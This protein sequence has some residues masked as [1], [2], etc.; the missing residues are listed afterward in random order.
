M[1][2]PL[3]PGP[4]HD[5]YLYP[6]QHLVIPAL[7]N[8]QPDL[9]VIAS[10]FDANGVDPLARMLLHSDSYRE[11]TRCLMLQ[12]ARGALRRTAG[13]RPRGRLCRSL[14]AL[15]RPG[16]HRNAVRQADRGGGSVSGLDSV[17]AAK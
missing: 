16:P 5:I 17:A 7:L 8:Y 6:M 3:L 14:C 13:H 9:I 11:M 4:G 10:G 2:I 12:V 1:N 15:L